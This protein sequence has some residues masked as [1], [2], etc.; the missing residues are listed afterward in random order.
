MFM[1]S[2]KMRMINVPNLD[3][4]NRGM[5]MSTSQRRSH[6]VIYTSALHCSLPQSELLK[7]K[8]NL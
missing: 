8:Q 6:C 4:G 3:E 1:E 2:R 5:E 7:E